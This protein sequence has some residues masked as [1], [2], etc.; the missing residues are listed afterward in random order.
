M[1]EL[2]F[3]FKMPDDE[4]LAKYISIKGEKGE[5]GDPTK[6]SQLDNDTGFVT[7]DTDALTN[8]YTKAQ[9]DSAID[10]DVE[11]LETE[12]GVP[13]GFFTDTSETATGEGTTITL[14]D[15]AN[16]VFKDIR[17][18]GDTQQDGTPTP[19]NPVEVQVVTG[20]QTIIISDND[21]QS[22]TYTISL[23]NIE[24]RKLG[25]YQ[26]YIY[27]GNDGW[28]LHKE[29][30]HATIDS[31]SDGV[32]YSIDTSSTNTTRV[33][34]T[35]CLAGQGIYTPESARLLAK[36]NYLPCKIMWSSDQ[37]GFF[38]DTDANLTKNGLVIRVPKSTIGTDSTSVEAWLNEHPLEVYYV[39][40]TA[41]DELITDLTLIA[42]LE[43]IAKA[44]S[45]DETTVISISGSLTSPLSVEAYT[46]NWNGTISGI[47]N[48]LD[49]A[50][51]KSEAESV[52]ND[53]VRFIFPKFW[54]NVFSGDCNLIKYR[55]KNILI[56]CYNP[57]SG[58][59]DAYAYVKAMLDENDVKHIDVF[60]CSHYHW[61][62]IGSFDKLAQDG[63]FSSSTKLFMPAE[64][65]KF[66]WEQSIEN[67]K[68]RCRNHGL[69]YYV[70]SEGEVYTIGNLKFT[71][72]NCDADAMDEY[73]PEGTDSQ[74]ATSMV[75]LVEHKDVKAFYAGDATRRTYTRLREQGFVTG[76]VNLHKIGHHGI[77]TAT[78]NDFFDKYNAEYAVI[79]GGILD[80]AKNNFGLGSEATILQA[81]GTRIYPTYMQ[82]DYIEMVS[83][84]STMTCVKGDQYVS[85]HSAEGKTVYVDINATGNDIQDGTEEHP[86]HEIMQAIGNYPKS[87]TTVLRIVLAE[88]D[89]CLSHEAGANHQKNTLTIRDLKVSI[90]A[91]SND[92]TATTINGIDVSNGFLSLTGVT[93]HVDNHKFVAYNSRVL[94]R[95]CIITT[96]DGEITSTN[97]GI[98]V[99]ESDVYIDDTTIENVNYGI[100]SITGSVVV[101]KNVTFGDLNSTAFV[102]NTNDTIL[103]DYNTTYTNTADKYSDVK[104][105]SHSI[106]PVLLYQSNDSSYPTSLNINSAFNKF[107]RIRIDY[108]T[109]RITRGSKTIYAPNNKNFVLHDVAHN[110]TDMSE[111]FL[112]VELSGSTVT[113]QYPL[114]RKTTFATDTVEY[115]QTAG[116]R[117]T[118]IWGYNDDQ[119]INLA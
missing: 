110:T 108:V 15:T 115:Q 10:A 65:T 64:T 53:R 22:Q 114:I 83:D 50:F 87:T 9:T 59:I 100:Y 98:D 93:V 48:G 30:D 77:E 78:D 90:S 24:L 94:V 84:G 23:G 6:L 109:G 73:Y 66:G 96:S 82:N 117:I 45:Y 28:Y 107:D 95:N 52:F 112:R 56:D 7:A 85:S 68:N 80:F 39:L 36:C 29:T 8:Y 16:A 41:T 5:K 34:M 63:Y 79:S 3:T 4:T 60:I 81:N 40:A 31:L 62:H 44:K 119:Q 89:Y 19:E 74:N 35:K 25:N 113:L 57:T 51:T 12:L 111:Y 76:K 47:N 118:H 58:N 2:N 54:A 49:N 27:K 106:A 17:F 97:N 55:D 14:N 102:R 13:D 18:Y 61:D 86:Y 43:A 88:G 69:T 105:Y 91:S 1:D 37:V 75:V 42:Q 26:D 71:F 104:H 33:T 72:G 38:I 70:P 32:S 11:A 99:H 67:Q 103:Y 101:T 21:Q 92:P 46:N 20:D 116:I